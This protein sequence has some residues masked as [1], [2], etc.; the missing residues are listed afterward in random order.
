MTS[1]PNQTIK[2]GSGIESL[3][4]LAALLET[5]QE[6]TG[7][8]E[9]GEL[10][11]AVAMRAQDLVRCDGVTL[12]LVEGE[13]LRPIL[14]REEYAEEVL[15]TPLKLGDGVSGSVAVT[16][17]AE[18]VNRVDLTGRGFLIPGTP[19]DPE[20]LLCAPLKYKDE[21]IGVLT[22]NRLGEWEFTSA[23]LEFTKGLASL[24][25]AAIHS[26][27]LYERLAD[28]ER[29][30]RT[31]F[32][33][34]GEAVFVHDPETKRLLDASDSAVRRYGYT[35]EEILSM[36][37]FDLHPEEER[38]SEEL[39]VP[40]DIQDGVTHYRGI[41]HRKKDGTLVE[42]TIS[43]VDIEL[44]GRPARLALAV[45]VTEWQRIFRELEQAR[46][47][48]S[49]GLLA[50]GIAHNLNGPLSGIQGFAELLRATH[51]ELTELDLI[52][53]QVHKINE[54]VRTLMLKAR[55]QQEQKS[56]NIQLNALL[57]TELAFLEANLFYKHEVE[58]SY[59]FDPMLPEVC[60]V[61]GDVSQALLN[62]INNAIDAMRDSPRRLLQVR[63]KHDD[64]QVII[65]IEDSGIGMSEEVVS[66]I[67]EPFFTTKPPPDGEQFQGPTGTGLGLSASRQFLARYNGRIEVRSKPNQGS[68][69]TI[70]LPSAKQTEAQQ[71]P[72]EE[73]TVA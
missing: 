49:I 35:R 51:P 37:I 22:L 62:I 27:R 36:T 34:I 40:A 54:I 52:L 56:R 71:P 55:H 13:V 70:I 73:F 5:S 61:Y 1:T 43:A 31:L 18:M 46:K 25:A 26:A 7:K 9:L 59:E 45:D 44:R 8:L 60:A 57:R 48:E 67:F 17:E 15:N 47:L 29:N 53:K 4:R 14:S 64:G 33:S 58:K 41:H 65:E 42:V 32:N 63:T 30:Y 23:D 11:E 16:G 72:G 38:E 66:R 6:I 39:H 12:Y 10:L 24:A 3:P 50:S 2:A 19:L 21:V 69:F 28:S 20:S 68:V